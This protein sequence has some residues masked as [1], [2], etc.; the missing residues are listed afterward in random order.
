M[1]KFFAGREPLGP[2]YFWIACAIVCLIGFALRMPTLSRSLWMD[3]TYSAW[4][5]ALPL[6]ELWTK[7]PLYET[8]PPMYYTLLKGWSLLFGT[9]EVALRA[10][11]V[12]ASVA[13]ILLLAVSGK[14][15]RAGPVGDRVALLA[16]LFLAV[17]KGSIDYAQQAR[18]YALETLAATIAILFSLI[19]LRAMRAQSGRALDLRPLWPS[20]LGLALATGMTLWLHDTAIFIALGI[21]AGLTLSLLFFVPGTRLVQAMVIGVPGVVALLLWSPFLPLFLA[22]SNNIHSMPFWITSKWSDLL[23]AWYLATGGG[24]LL[25]FLDGMLGLAGFVTLWRTERFSAVHLATILLLPLAI[26]LS[27]N[28]LVKP[29]FIDRLFEWMTPSVMAFVALGVI[30]GLRRITLRK[31]AALAVIGFSLVSIYRYYVY[32]TENWRGWLNLISSNARPGDLVIAIPNEIDPSITYYV[33]RRTI[34]PDILFIPAPFPALGL[35]RRYIGNL[36]APAIIPA[37]KALVRAALQNHHRVWLIERDANLYDPQ[38]SIRAQI[39]S[40]RK[41][42]GSYGSGIT[43]IELFD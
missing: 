43:S 30:A 31:W 20:M 13:T 14:T 21:W 9:T 18:P 39:L 37:D 25:L 1:N 12:V 24:K 23:G 32:P 17:N 38:G 29:I 11:S 16:A 26:I 22:Q 3:E 27:V 40:S 41:L 6:H 8:H 33:G 10:M 34:F 5:S 42:V 7:V 28:Y 36:G 19:L 2:R 35:K 4:F 15:L